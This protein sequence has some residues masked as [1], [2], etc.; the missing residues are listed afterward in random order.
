MNIVI[1]FSCTQ[2]SYGINAS[3]LFCY[4]T[5]QNSRN[6][7]VEKYTKS[8]FTVCFMIFCRYSE[9]YATEFHSKIGLFWWG[10]ESIVMILVDL[11]LQLYYC[12]YL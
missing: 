7:H 10:I 1:S 12:G 2:G 9:A 11:K 4:E 6:F 8:Q 3:V 5:S